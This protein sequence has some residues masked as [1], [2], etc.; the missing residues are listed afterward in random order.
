MFTDLTM[1]ST[2]KRHLISTVSTIKVGSL[3]CMIIDLPI[4]LWSYFYSDSKKLGPRQKLNQY[5]QLWICQDNDKL[6]KRNHFEIIEDHVI[7]KF[8]EIPN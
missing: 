8:I 2:R 7:E 6:H 1:V 4:N 3:I 5:F